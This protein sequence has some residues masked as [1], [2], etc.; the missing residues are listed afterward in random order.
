M[1]IAGLASAII[2][3]V[4][5]ALKGISVFRKFINKLISEGGSI[6]TLLHGLRTLQHAMQAVEDILRAL[7]RQGRD[8]ESMASNILLVIRDHMV[9]CQSDFD[10]WQAVV[11]GFNLARN[12]LSPKD[13]L[14]RLKL[15]VE[16][17]TSEE[18]QQ[19]VAQHQT[20]LFVTTNLLLFTEY[21]ACHSRYLR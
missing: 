5:A 6:S 7:A 12:K 10:Q 4:G 14:T 2:A 21:V 19:R 8:R 18:L 17:N 3:L 11:N 9:S 13:M 15:A 1:T 20:N 16:M